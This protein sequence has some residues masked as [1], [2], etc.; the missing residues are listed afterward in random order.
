MS[1]GLSDKGG[2]IPIFLGIGTGSIKTMAC[3]GGKSPKN[4]YLSMVFGDRMHEVMSIELGSDIF[5]ES[6]YPAHHFL[7]NIDERRVG[8]IGG[9]NKE[10][11]V[12]IKAQ[13]PS[14]IGGHGMDRQLLIICSQIINGLIEVVRL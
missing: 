13:A 4:I 8:V 14:I 3:S 9:R 10:I 11:I 2:C 1:G 7:R 6:P 5:T 12:F